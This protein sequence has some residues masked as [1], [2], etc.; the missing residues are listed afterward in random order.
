LNFFFF[1][2]FIF[3]YSFLFRQSFFRFIQLDV[4]ST[5]HLFPP[6]KKH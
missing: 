5:L 3:S 2:F 6:Y 4:V 1:Y